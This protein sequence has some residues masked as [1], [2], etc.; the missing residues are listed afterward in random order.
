MSTAEGISEGEEGQESSHDKESGF[1]CQIVW[2]NLIESKQEA[3]VKALVYKVL[4]PFQ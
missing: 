4:W 3:V 1:F 2:S